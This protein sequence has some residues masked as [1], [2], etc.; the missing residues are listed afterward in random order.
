MLFRRPRW[1]NC[2]SSRREAL[3][4]LRLPQAHVAS[5]YAAQFYAEACTIEALVLTLRQLLTDRAQ[6]GGDPKAEG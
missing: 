2:G 3:P 1:R 4:E 6:Q 5:I